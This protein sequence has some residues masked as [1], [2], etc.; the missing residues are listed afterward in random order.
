[1]IYYD[2]FSFPCAFDTEKSYRFS[3]KLYLNILQD[4][5]LFQLSS[6]S[7]GSEPK[8]LHKPQLSKSDLAGMDLTSEKL[9]MNKSVCTTY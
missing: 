1:M 3:K 5:F 4:Q 7:S 8:L 9:Y 2:Y 6:S